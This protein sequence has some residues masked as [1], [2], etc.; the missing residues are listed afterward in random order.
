MSKMKRPGFFR[1]ILFSYGY[2]FVEMGEY[3]A[4]YFKT[5]ILLFVLAGLYL[6]AFQM[7]D[8]VGF[9]NLISLKFLTEVM[10][11]KPVPTEYVFKIEQL[12]KLFLIVGAFIFLL[13][14]MAPLYVSIARRHILNDPIDASLF[15]RLFKAPQTTQVWATIKVMLLSYLAMLLFGLLV[16]GIGMAFVDFLPIVAPYIDEINKILLAN[17]EPEQGILMWALLVYGAAFLLALFTIIPLLGR[18]TWAL[19]LSSAGEGSSIRRAFKVAKGNGIYTFFQLFFV[20]IPL[21]IVVGIFIGAVVFLMQIGML[22]SYV[23]FGLVVAIYMISIVFHVV[24][25]SA[26]L[27]NV[28]GVVHKKTKRY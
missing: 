8:P 4:L 9:Q 24:L 12:W 18:M 2:M 22:Q 21:M 11:V 19:A 16:F 15:S 27:G 28:V 7:L 23:A 6:A 1:N 3:G 26:A 10:Q 13:F 25:S 17:L 14:S 5:L 20:A